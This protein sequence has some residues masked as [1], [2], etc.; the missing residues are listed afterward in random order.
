LKCAAAYWPPLSGSLEQ[1]VLHVVLAAT[2]AQA[3]APSQVL[4]VQLL[5]ALTQTP[6][7][8][9]VPAPTGLQVP[10]ES[11][12]QALQLGH[13]E[14]LQQRESTQVPVP[15]FDVPTHGSPSLP[16][17][18]AVRVTTAVLLP[19]SVHLSVAVF[20]PVLVGMALT[21][22]VQLPPLALRVALPQFCVMI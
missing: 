22:M 8:S 18:V 21:V 13:E 7:G 12:L 15:Q 3:P 11:T 9:T 17:T 10:L 6:R 20:D 16:S 14:L 19:P 5:G 2:K 4:S 1:V